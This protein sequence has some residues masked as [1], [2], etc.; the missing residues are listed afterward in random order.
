[1]KI[2]PTPPIFTFFPTPISTP[3]LPKPN[4]NPKSSPPISSDYHLLPPSFIASQ[5]KPS[6]ASFNHQ[7][8]VNISITNPHNVKKKFENL[9]HYTLNIFVV[10]G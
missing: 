2:N 4:H 3:T 10:H 6:V 1:M 7:I 8:I 9:V 5:C